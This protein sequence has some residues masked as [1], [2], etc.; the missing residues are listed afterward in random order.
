MDAL[1]SCLKS[2]R[3]QDRHKPECTFWNRLNSNFRE[4]GKILGVPFSDAILIVHFIIKQIQEHEYKPSGKESMNLHM[5]MEY[6]RILTMS[7]R[8][9]RQ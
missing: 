8:K 2:F 6:E 7:N 3:C 4:L 9:Q 1:Y 5:H